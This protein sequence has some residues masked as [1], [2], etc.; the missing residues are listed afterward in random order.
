MEGLLAAL[1]ESVD[2]T[3]DAADQAAKLLEEYEY[4]SPGSTKATAG[5]GLKKA[6]KK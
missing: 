3:S 4:M 6:G 2:K 1:G 5:K